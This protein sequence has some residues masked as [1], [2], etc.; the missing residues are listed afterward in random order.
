M[1]HSIRSKFDDTWMSIAGLSVG[2]TGTISIAP[3]STSLRASFAR[4]GAGA[5]AWYRA[6]SDPVVGRALKL[7]HIDPGHAWTVAALAVAY[8]ESEWAVRLNAAA[9]AAAESLGA[10]LAVPVRELYD[11]LLA[12]AQRA[13]GEEGA[14]AAR[15]VGRGLALRQ[16]VDD[17]LTWLS[18]DAGRARSDVPASPGD[19]VRSAPDSRR[20]PRLQSL[21]S[22]RSRRP[23]IAPRGPAIPTEPGRNS[24]SW[25]RKCA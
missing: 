10:V 8:G 4:P 20:R 23:D 7:M 3:P 17:A 16:A 13:L 1:T 14:A 22:R 2:T 15:Q 5:P 25:A 12:P 6:Q 19:P 21:S 18:E 11:A 9:S 24:R